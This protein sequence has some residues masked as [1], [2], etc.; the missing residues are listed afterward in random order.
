MSFYS[1]LI[2]VHLGTAIL[3]PSL[4][5][6]SIIIAVSIAVKPA[7][8]Q[9]NEGLLRKA[10]AAGLAEGT[11]AVIVTLTG[12]IAVFMGPWSFSELWLW[13]S[14]M[15]MVFYVAALLF[16]TKPARLLV[17]TDGSAVKCGM[18]VAL[19]IAHGLLII[20]SYALMLLKPL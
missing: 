19:Q 8:D 20:V 11:V 3:L 9:A 12:V 13:M 18:Q 4:V 7:A 5:I 17:A 14:L 16:V 1:A 10:N 15:T 2:I 6:I